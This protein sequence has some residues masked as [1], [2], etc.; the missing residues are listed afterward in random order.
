LI[1]QMHMDDL[2]NTEVVKVDAN[3]NGQPAAPAKTKVDQ[4]M[5]KMR[6]DLLGSLQG[7]VRDEY[8]ITIVDIRLKRFNHPIKVRETIFSRIISERELKAAYYRNEGKK[9]ADDIRSAAD[10]KVDMFSRAAEK[11]EKETKRQ[12][13]AEAAVILAA[14]FRQDVGFFRFWQEMEQMKSILGNSKTTLLLSTHRGMFDFLFNVPGP[15]GQSLGG[16]PN[17]GVPSLNG[18][19]QAPGKED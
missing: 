4:T 12:A 16:R 6:Q 8:G 9:R 13:E 18:T 3:A 14:A 15:D 1:G 5:D 10:A 19:S 11:V 17:L 7:P 2:I